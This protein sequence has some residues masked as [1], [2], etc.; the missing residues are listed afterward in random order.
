[1]EGVMMCNG[2]VYGLAVRK[3]NGEICAQRL[4]WKS[5]FKSRWKR[6]PFLR[7]FPILLE[8]LLNGIH[9][10]NRSA[11]LADDACCQAKPGA[12]VFSLCIA[13]V[14]ALGLFVLA[15]H[16][17]SLLMLR[18]RAGGDVDGLSFHLWDGLFKTLIFVGYISLISLVPDIRR[19]FQYHGAEHKTIHA[20]EHGS[21]RFPG[22]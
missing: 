7:G 3:A 17:L 13:L 12:A 9:A 2:D 14:L 5:C 1:M 20:F 16:L 8:T 4:P 11:A 21:H 18:L 10:L 19:V 6:L 15:P 22:G